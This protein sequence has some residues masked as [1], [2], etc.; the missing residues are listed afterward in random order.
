MLLTVAEAVLLFKCAML[1]GTCRRLPSRGLDSVH[2]RRRAARLTAMTPT[3]TALPSWRRYHSFSIRGLIFLIL[4]IAAALGLV[5]NRGGVQRRGVAAIEKAGGKVWYDWEW[6][7]GSPVASS[8]PRWPTW[9]VTSVGNDYFGSAAYVS[10]SSRK[11][12]RELAHVANL[13]H[14]A[15]LDLSGSAVTDKALASLTRLPQLDTL[16]LIRTNLG[17]SALV[18]LRGLRNLRLLSQAH[19]PNGD[20]GRT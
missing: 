15:R 16:L 10:L 18:H 19:T 8:G 17:D 6:Q 9:L 2:Y 20:E 3:K 5:G 1:P 11:T 7:D 14:L 4:F 13:E 12:D